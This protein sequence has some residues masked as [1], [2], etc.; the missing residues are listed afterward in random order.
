ME[1][2][3]SIVLLLVGFVSFVPVIQ[4]NKGSGDTKYKCLKYLMNTAFAW[5]ILIFVERFSSN[6]NIVYYS[7][8]LGYPIKFLLGAFMLCTIYNYVEKHLPKWI[9]YVFG[10]LFVAELIVAITNASTEFM[11]EIKPSEIT[12]YES[13]YQAT[14]GPIFIYHLILIYFILLIAIVTL[15][16]FLQKNREV[17]QYKAV[18]RTMVG[19][20]IVVLTFN[21]LQLFVVES[22]V[23]LTYVSLIVVAYA[24]YLVIYRRDMVFNLLN[25]GRGEILSNMR[26][27][28]IITDQDKR[29]VEMSE[30]LKTKYEVSLNDFVGKPLN[31]LIDELSSKIVFY[32]EYDVDTEVN[33]KKDHFHLREKKF[34]LKGMNAYGFMIL[35]Y[36][37]TQVFTLLRELNQLSNYDT[38]TGLHNRNYIEHKLETY[39][40]GNNLG[41][42]SLDLNGLKAN[43]DYLG[44]ERG[45]YLLKTLATN[46]KKSLMVI[47]H[48]EMARIGGDE[49][50]VL[51]PNTTEDLVEQIKQDILF[52]CENEDLEKHISVSI[53]TAFDD[54]GKVNVYT[55]IQE[56]DK[57]M[58]EM[59]SKTSSV[60]SKE[61]VTYAKKLDKYIR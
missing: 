39:N 47:E 9:L 25:S 34:Q 41:V 6:L 58:Y 5:T 44:H 29:I 32:R 22:S 16:Y 33:E 13:L 23:D 14:E 1:V 40:K 26:E 46:M 51:L 2:F 61:I 30:L 54:E 52:E 45:D 24:L 19:S 28:Y 53:G 56:A 15:F 35:L 50:L 55:L 31:D 60:Y 11:L 42:I 43:N 21:S 3:L 8:V 59:K 17:R 49:F 7:H 57:S 48:K 4:M 10:I 18:S 38:M 36:D 37:E 12:S 20:I 27:M